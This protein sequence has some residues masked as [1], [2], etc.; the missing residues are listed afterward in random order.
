MDF[1][2][3]VQSNDK[4]KAGSILRIESDILTVLQG[5]NLCCET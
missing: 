2:V 5:L 4:H 1:V 3:S